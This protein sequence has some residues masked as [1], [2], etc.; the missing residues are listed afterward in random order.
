MLVCEASDYPVC[1]TG[2]EFPGQRQTDDASRQFEV[3]WT[4]DPR[5]VRDAA[6]TCARLADSF[7][8]GLDL[9]GRLPDEPAPPVSADLRRATGLLTRMTSYLDHHPA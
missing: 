1:L 6:R 5:P 2:W 3:M 7:S 9:L 8:P 4:L